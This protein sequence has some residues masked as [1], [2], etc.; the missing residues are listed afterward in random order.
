MSKV[1]Q[2]VRFPFTRSRSMAA[3]A[4]R[5][6]IQVGIAVILGAVILVIGIMWIGDV[7]LNQNWQTY[8]VYFDQV[9]GL[10]VG[11]PV[12]IFG[13][14]L[15]KVGSISLEDGRVRA[16]LLIQ[17]G[18]V[19]RSDCS[20]EIRSIGLMGEKYI[21]I[22]PG[23]NGEI[24]PPGSSIEGEY[25]AGLPEVVAGVGEMMAD[26]KAAAAVLRDALGTAGDEKGLGQS[27]ANLDAMLRE[28]ITLLRE[29]RDDVKAT[30]ENMRS[31]SEGLNDVIG[32]RK[33][34]IKHG[35]D[36]FS[37]AAQRF[38]SLTVTLRQIADSID[39]GEGSLGMLIKEKK[40][41]EQLDATLENL[42]LLIE[43]IREHPERYITIEIF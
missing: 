27:L 30:A 39:R 32:S 1:E 2:K 21:H 24:L 33:E 18:V 14:E 26:M 25:S 37:R 4:R 36:R 20:V 22:L 17:E 43:D 31:A 7:R 35:I 3:T 15:G 42:N 19:L 41:H 40:L 23:K 28:I 10:E 12:N 16:D 9:G 5:T 11:D 13:L 8:T 38:D 29:T 6:E 34:E